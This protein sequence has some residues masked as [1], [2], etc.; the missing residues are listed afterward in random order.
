MGTHSLTLPGPYGQR[1]RA[2]GKG[3]WPSPSQGKSEPEARL[4]PPSGLAQAL[5]APCWDPEQCTWGERTYPGSHCPVLGMPFL[6]R[7]DWATFSGLLNKGPL[8]EMGE[9]A[10][11][12][13]EAMASFPPPQSGK[14]PPSVLKRTGAGLRQDVGGYSGSAGP[15]GRCS[16]QDPEE[17][18]CEQESPSKGPGTLLNGGC[19]V[20]EISRTAPPD[21]PA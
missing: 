13:T 15:G 3:G 12:G 6:F 10:R 11:S 16:Q 21:D 1:G 14:V 18:R 19:P 20:A 7:V 8:R 5:P 2:R 4:L 9:V 17:A